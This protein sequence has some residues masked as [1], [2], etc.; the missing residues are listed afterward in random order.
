MLVLAIAPDG[1]GLMHDKS[2]S[3]IEEVKARKGTLLSLC[4]AGDSSLEKIS[5]AT[6]PIVRSA[7][8]DLLPILSV[9]SL[10]LFS[11]YVAIEKGTDVDQPRNLAKSVT[12]E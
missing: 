5:Q 1:S 9:L 3:N 12:V 10:Q 8:A 6:I 7:F 2:V 11:Y 4:A